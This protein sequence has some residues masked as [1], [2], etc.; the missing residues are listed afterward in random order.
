MIPGSRTSTFLWL[1]GTVR[2]AAVGHKRTFRDVFSNVRLWLEADIL[3]GAPES[4]LYPQKRTLV[5]PIFVR[6]G[7]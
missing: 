1:A 4:P 2:M 7:N 6:F 3:R 5:R